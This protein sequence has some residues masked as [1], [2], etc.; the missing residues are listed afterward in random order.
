MF[1]QPILLALQTAGI[2]RG[3]S[4]VDDANFAILAVLRVLQSSKT[5]RDFIQFHGM[6]A[7]E[8]LTRSNYFGSLASPR[9]LGMMIALERALQQ[10]QLPA[11]RCHD[12]HLATL[13][14]L[15][16]WEVWAGDGHCIA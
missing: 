1:F 10:A 2:T 5:G 7:V 15:D 4:V 6:S 12:D 13:S 16:H 3:C 11:L 9:R 14:E 8:G